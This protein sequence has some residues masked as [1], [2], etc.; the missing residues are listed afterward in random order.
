MSNKLE[1]FQKEVENDFVQ[2][3]LANALKDGA[4]VFTTS[5]I[6]LYSSES[7]LQECKPELVVREAMKAVS[8]KL[9]IS[10]GLGFA[11]VVA[12]KGKPSFQIGYKGYIQLAIRSGLYDTINAD[13]VYEG[14]YRSTDKL[15]GTFDLTGTRK[16]DI[17]I[18]FFAHMEL[19]NGFTKTLYMSVQQ[20]HA[21]AKRY[22]PT[23]NSEYSPWKKDFEGMGKKTVV[24]NLLS[25]WG[26]LSVEMEDAF[27]RDIEDE[28]E[29]NANQTEMRFT[30]AEV[31]STETTNKPANT[32]KTEVVTPVHKAPF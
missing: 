21:H 3:A 18:G 25:H 17:V 32:S 27:N 8:L 22:S 30:E 19:K 5:L 2:K 24:K 28:I 14:E 10:K 13:M 15:K 4:G 12:Y 11:Y 29:A 23:Y 16:S 1:L 6:D 26:T 9:P 31:V 20:V 7:S